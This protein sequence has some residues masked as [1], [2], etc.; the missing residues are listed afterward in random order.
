MKKRLVHGTPI[1]PKRLLTQLKD[2]SFCVSYMRPEQLN[3]TIEL[4]G[5]DEILILD[6]GA[7][8]ACS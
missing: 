2:K 6:N 3:E 4:V 5:K 7:F 1:T 8:T